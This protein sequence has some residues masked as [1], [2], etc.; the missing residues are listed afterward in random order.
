MPDA[1]DGQGHVD[2]GH[3]EGAVANSLQGLIET[4]GPAKAAEF[5]RVRGR[6]KRQRQSEEGMSEHERGEPQHELA[7]GRDD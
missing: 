7:T 6:R 2:E 5:R 1:E 3:C 4:A